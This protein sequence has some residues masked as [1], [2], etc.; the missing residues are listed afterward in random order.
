MSMIETV[1]KVAV[2]T[3]EFMQ[4]EV[5]LDDQR[6]L[7]AVI[8]E[9]QITARYLPKDVPRQG[10]VISMDSGSGKTA[11]CERAAKAAALEAGAKDG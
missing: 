5:D 9:M 10:M 1:A 2:A 8:R 11:T 3:V 4:I 6:R 7:G